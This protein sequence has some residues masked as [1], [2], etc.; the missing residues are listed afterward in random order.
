MIKLF[1]A[2]FDPKTYLR[3]KA[4]LQRLAGQFLILVITIVGI[5]WAIP[6]LSG[7]NQNNP[8]GAIQISCRDCH[9]SFGEKLVPPL[10]K[11]DHSSTRYPLQGMHK[12]LDC[13]ECHTDRVFSRVENQC[14]DCHA[15]IHRRQMGS[16]CEQCHSA[17]GWQELRKAVNGHINRFPLIGAHATVECE[18][19][20]KGAAVGLFRGLGT[21]CVSCHSADYRN[22]TP[23]HADAGFSMKCETC[24]STDRW[25]RKFNHGGVT[26]FALSG[27][28]A[29]LDC[30][31]CHIGGNFKGA[32]A[33]CASCHIQAYNNVANPNHITSGFSQNCSQCHNST[34]WLGAVFG[35]T[36][37][38]F[39]LTGAHVG[40]QCQACHVNNQYKGLPSTCFACHSRQ[41]SSVT[42]PNHAAAGFSQD[43]L[44]C[45]STTSWTGATFTHTRFP[46]YS[47]THAKRWS[48]CN[49]CHPN[50]SSYAVFS[51]I[52]CHG[53]ASTDG[54]HREVSSYVYNS[55]NCYSCHP[56]GRA[57]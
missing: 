23:N 15:D 40:L 13:V 53:K 25:D 30:F 14:S 31:Q 8:H 54:D 37:S 19:C 34:S 22:A 39:K 41:Y 42:D 12:R 5:Y 51:C 45:H 35:H 49:D 48:S 16:N 47:G 56:S 29:Q 32:S 46:I 1:S 21:E 57:D 33:D 17:Q 10:P 50:S 55:A 6:N 43:C 24:H 44:T 18:G 2:D 11:F 38:S 26:G 4:K 27:A 9:T 28:H 52:T 36:T 7:Q 3:K 20:H